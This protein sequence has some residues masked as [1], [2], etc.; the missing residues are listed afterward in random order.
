MIKARPEDFIVEERADLPLSAAGRFAVY[1]LHKRGW[2]TSDLVRHLARLFCL[3]PD[4]IA[5]GGKKDKHGQTAQ[6]ITIEDAADRSGTGKDYRLEAAGRMDRPMGPDLIRA[7]DFS[8]TI[9]DLSDL[10]VLEP[11][12]DRIRAGGFP[13]WFDDQRF[14]SY[15]SDRGFFAEKILR[16]HWN[17]ALQV[18]F[19]SVTPG[20]SGRERVRRRELF[21]VWRDWKA[22]RAI[23]TNALERAVFDV[24]RTRPE[25]VGE[26]LHRIPEEET[27]MQFAVFQAHLWNETLRRILRARNIAAAEVPGR[28]GP[29][30]FWREIPEADLSALRALHLPT[31]AAKMEFPDREAE[32]LFHAVLAEKSLTRADFRTRELRRV[33]FQSFL[34]PAAVVPVDFRVLE[35]GSDEL[36][37][38]RKK[39]VLRFALPRG[40]YAT[41]LVKYLALSRSSP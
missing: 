26:A 24:L 9:R 35:R 20:L 8:I 23:A 29:Y 17:G 11:A 30:L 40:S 2:N 19:T 16:R 5:Y 12:L 38:G 41:I 28:E 27:A 37:P 31:A 10:R 14:R 6:F 39:I 22:C 21:R 33:R 1:R 15:D 18:F 34:R 3:P 4:R 7:N 32:I 13:N 36:H 25:D